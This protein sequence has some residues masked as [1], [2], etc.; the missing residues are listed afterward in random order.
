MKKFLCVSCVV[1][2]A[3]LSV[4]AN[5]NQEDPEEVKNAIEEAFENYGKSVVEADVDTFLAIHTENAIKM[6][7]GRPPMIMDASFRGKLE[8]GWSRKD[9]IEFKVE[10]DEVEMFGDF[11]YAMGSYF[12][13]TI[14]NGSEEVVPEEGKFL[15]V[16]KKQSDGSWKI[17][18]DSFSSNT[19]PA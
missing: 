9:V 5:G 19:P 15:T 7:A 3:A 11:A 18:R 12:K 13:K 6:G 16:F 4:S 17:Y 8:K 2:I 14:F 1:I 10:I